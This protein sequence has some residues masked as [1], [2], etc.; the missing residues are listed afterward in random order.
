MKKTLL[1]LMAVASV[2]CITAT[3]FAQVGV[4]PQLRF[5][6]LLSGFNVQVP[7]GATVGLGTSNVLNTTYAGQILFSLTNNTV[8][9][10]LQSNIFTGD[11]FKTATLV[12]AADGSLPANAAV[13]ILIGNTNLIPVAVT[14]SVGQYFVTNW[15]LAN[16]SY[17]NWMYPGTTNGYNGVTA[18][19]TN[20]L[21]VS[22]YRSTTM[23][24]AGGVGASNTP[25]VPM[26]ETTAGFSFTVAPNGVTPVSIITNLPAGF[27]Q[28]AKVV[29]CTIAST[30]TGGTPILVNQVGI[31]QPQ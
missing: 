26:W 25:D 24:L 19:S 5:N 31:M 10:V 11:A 23:K 2:L 12:C 20:V 22:L 30:G 27:L 17:P 18:T 9:G 15:V 14:N 6:P 7:I 16:N 28:G 3:A 4:A 1:K 13:Q 29:K 8:N 21:T